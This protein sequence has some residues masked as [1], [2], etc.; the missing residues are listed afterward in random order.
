MLE[1][2]YVRP[3]T[4]DRIRASWIADP[5]ESYVE[6]VRD[7]GYSRSSVRTRVAVLYQFGEFAAN[8]GASSWSEL[9]KHIETFV[10]F[11][12]Q[13]HRRRFRSA[14]PDRRWIIQKPVE[15]MLQCVLPDFE[16]PRQR[17]RLPVPFAE[18]APGFFPYLRTERGLSENTIRHYLHFLRRFERHLKDAGR[19]DLQSLCPEVLRGFVKNTASTLSTASVASACDSVRVFLRYLHREEILDRDLSPAVERPRSYRLDR[20]PRSI[21]WTETRPLL[22]QIDRR[23]KV[24]KRDF[25]IVLLLVTYGLRAHEVATLTL[26][27]IDWRAGILRISQRKGGHSNHYRLTPAAGDALAEYIEHARPNVQ[28]RRIFFAM[29]APLRPLQSNGISQRVSYWLKRA[30]ISVP[31]AGAHTLRHTVV[32]HLLDHDL[33]LQQIGDYV[34][35]RSP[36]STQIYTKV[37][38]L[39][40]REIA[41]GYGEEVLG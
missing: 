13:R 19:S 12:K 23:S 9:P 4:I 38:M 37:D 24:G 31:R 15:E 2:Y 35:H 33:T 41:F 20:M 10:A 25:A 36:N 16:R 1:H 6:L 30:D 27:D 40:L 14:A 3:Q 17:T 8:R 7:R 21:P 32:Q 34:G 11:W 39:R 28:D 22:R 5:I 26:E 29:Y 18:E